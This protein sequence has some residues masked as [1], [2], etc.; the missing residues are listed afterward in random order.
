MELSDRDLLERFAAGR[1]EAAFRLLVERHLPLVHGV[2][3]RITANEDLAKDV[4]QDTFMRLARRAALIPENLSLTAWLHRVAQHLAIDLVR[5]ES[6]RKKREIANP[7]HA[8][9]SNTPSP[10][11][12]ALAP[13]VDSLINRLPTAEREVLLLRYYRDQPHAE[14]ARQLGVSEVVAKKRAS[15]ALEK[16]RGL[17]ASRGIATTTAALATLLPAN[18]ATP[19]S[20]T[21]ALSISTVS[22]GVIPLAPQGLNLHLAMTS[23]QKSAIA[24]A[25]IV[26]MTSLGYAFR[27]SP[28]DPEAGVKSAAALT[29]GSSES[30]LPRTRNERRNGASSRERLERLRSILALS[31][32]V[33]QPRQM[34]AFIGELAPDQF[35]ETAD[36]LQEL[37]VDTGSSNFRMFLAAWAKRH[38]LGAVGWARKSSA[39]GIPAVIFKTW[40]ED[41]PATA[42]DWVVRNLPDVTGSDAKARLPLVQILS[43]LATKDASAVV[44]ALGVIPDEKD[45]IEALNA[46]GTTLR[47]ED[48]ERLIA[49]TSDGPQRS[50]IVG[51]SVKTFADYSKYGQAFELLLADKDARHLADI[52]SLFARWH[53]DYPEDTLAAIDALPEAKVR[54]QAKAGVLTRVGLLEP[55]DAIALLD[56]HPE[57]T[58]DPLMLL[59]ADRCGLVLGAEFSLRIQDRELRDKTLTRHLK[60]WLETRQEPAARKWIEQHEIPPSVREVLETRP[61]ENP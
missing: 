32:R 1:D 15:R 30:T 43:S 61:S 45:R 18:A 8:A 6:R 21:L 20:S 2:A 28:E 42:V 35:E 22:K 37:G 38:P 55:A 51:A 41:D 46:I 47:I 60:A 23:V 9:M 25:A 48:L 12:S 44:K 17:L 14:V 24:G 53:N 56:Q 50:A 58:S 33:E 34:L 3:R 31:S 52:E 10:D 16:L 57:W 39:G 4:A 27:S 49:A 29:A 7:Y 26:F 54:E 5:A 13:L 36:Q 40:G 11:W 19:V 59:V